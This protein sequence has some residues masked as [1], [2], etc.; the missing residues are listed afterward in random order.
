[1]TIIEDFISEGERQELLDWVEASEIPVL[2][3]P[4]LK[5][6]QT[7]P[8]RKKIFDDDGPQ[9]YYDIQARIAERFGLSDRSPSGWN[10]QVFIHQPDMFT[11]E[12]VDGGKNGA[13]RMTLMIQGA[14]DGGDLIHDSS[15][16]NI[17]ECGLATY[18]ASIPHEVST[19]VS[20]ERIVFI[21]FWSDS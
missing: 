3:S 16:I 1:M 8:R 12:H 5:F 9:L 21:F 10:G 20:G 14:E 18:D 4:E 19:V 17:P 6:T 11:R 15:I 2:Q 7:I 13:F